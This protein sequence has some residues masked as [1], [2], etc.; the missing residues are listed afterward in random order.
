MIINIL[1][2]ILLYCNEYLI[3]FGTSAISAKILLHSQ[4]LMVRHWPNGNPF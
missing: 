3:Y 2:E 4:D 1:K